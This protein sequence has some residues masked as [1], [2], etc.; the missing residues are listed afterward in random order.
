[1][2]HYIPRFGDFVYIAFDPQS[3]HEQ[4]GRR[5]ALVTSNSL[6][7]QKTGMAFVCPVTSTV[8]GNPFHL[9]IPTQNSVTGVVMVDQIKSVDYASRNVEFIAPAPESLV[10]DVVS[11]LNTILEERF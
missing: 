5:P 2:V 7:N 1:M 9:P 8:R 4:K 6:F 3:G 11:L 10:A